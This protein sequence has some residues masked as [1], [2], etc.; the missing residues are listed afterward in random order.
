VSNQSHASPGIQTHTLA[1]ST[2]QRDFLE[3]EHVAPHG[4]IQVLGGG[5]IS[6][7]EP[8]RFKPDF[9]AK[10]EIRGRLGIPRDAL[11]F[12]FL[13]RVTRD[14]GIRE[15]RSAFARSAN[16]LPQAHLIVV[17][18]IENHESARVFG[19]ESPEA[20]RL[21]VVGP[22]QAPERFLAASDV[23]V[24]PSYREW[25]RNHGLGGGGLRAAC[26]RVK[27]LR[28]FRCSCRSLH[29][30]ARS[31]RGCLRPGRSDVRTCAESIAPR[32]NG[33]I[34]PASGYRGVSYVA[35]YDG[36]CPVPGGSDHE[37]RPSGLLLKGWGVVAVASPAQADGL[38]LEFGR[39]R[40]ARPLRLDG[41]SGLVHGALLASILANLGV[42][43]IEASSD[44]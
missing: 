13:G 7:V 25:V 17:G 27:H 5:S 18:P 20:N 42:H 10:A 1:D 34:G 29:R 35:A 44:Y 11:V 39:E 14:K 3:G 9:A 40:A 12:V 37:P 19:G 15:L 41:L 23:L 38:S 33:E 4:K 6:G 43:E 31:R 24:L 16:L 30:S 26:N 32:A 8:D 21:H 36:V 28:A 22:T 2:S